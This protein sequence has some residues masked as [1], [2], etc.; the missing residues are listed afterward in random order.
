MPKILQ[1]KWAILKI[2]K[3]HK[4]IVRMTTIRVLTPLMRSWV[5]KQVLLAES[6]TV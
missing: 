3:E 4:K 5:R 2:L 1:R 6:M